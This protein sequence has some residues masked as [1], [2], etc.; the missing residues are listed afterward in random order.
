MLVKGDRYFLPVTLPIEYNIAH[1]LQEAPPHTEEPIPEYQPVDFD[2][3]APPLVCNNA[4]G[5]TLH[6]LLLQS[7][8]FN[9]Q[10]P[11]DFFSHFGGCVLF[12]GRMA[13][14]IV[15]RRRKL[16]RDVDVESSGNGHNA[17]TMQDGS[18]SLANRSPR[19]LSVK[20]SGTIG[21]HFQGQTALEILAEHSANLSISF[22]EELWMVIA[23]ADGGTGQ[24]LGH[25]CHQGFDGLQAWVCAAIV[26]NQNV[27][28]YD[29][30]LGVDRMSIAEVAKELLNMVYLGA[31][32]AN[33]C[34]LKS[35]KFLQLPACFQNAIIFIMHGLQVVA[36]RCAAVKR[37]NFDGLFRCAEVSS[38]APRMNMDVIFTNS[39]M[40]ASLMYQWAC[41]ALK[42]EPSRREKLFEMSAANDASGIAESYGL[43]PTD[44]KLGCGRII[45]V[46]AGHN[47]WLH[48][49]QL[50]EYK[51]LLDILVRRPN[52]R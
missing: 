22:L 6:R 13:T 5:K 24:L 18:G 33:G 31:P 28:S 23:R 25:A 3:T 30:Q 37:N 46:H 4:H 43:S 21:E 39:C 15:R 32:D 48:L 8:D 7:Y 17:S 1:Y 45:S 20:S 16:S 10:L 19:G 14:K 35:S 42:S 49:E 52:N 47:G 41:C 34:I 44:T 51:R 29:P 12:V 9:T 27:A 38:L 2:E 11:N 40:F 36:N 26:Y 50:N